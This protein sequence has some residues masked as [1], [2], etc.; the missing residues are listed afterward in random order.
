MESV[1]DMLVLATK[2]VSNRL[3]VNGEALPGWFPDPNVAGRGSPRPDLVG[4]GFYTFVGCRD[5]QG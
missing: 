1:S 2:R 4:G 5:G 3:L